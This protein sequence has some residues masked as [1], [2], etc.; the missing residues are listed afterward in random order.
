M[1]K[2]IFTIIA[3]VA[4]FTASAQQLPKDTTK[5][6]PFSFTEILKANQQLQRATD[7]YHS[8]HMDARLRDTIDAYLY[9]VRYLINRR[10][11]T[12]YAD[13]VKKKV[14]QK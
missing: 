4:V 5:K 1:R 7:L 9:D 2:T 11:Q 6:I 10:T 8:V 3:I 12:V 14:N 13:T